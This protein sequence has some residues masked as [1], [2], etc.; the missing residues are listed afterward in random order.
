M[1]GFLGELGILPNNQLCLRRKPF[2]LGGS[3]GELG[4][5][6]PNQLM[7]G[8]QVPMPN[9]NKQQKVPSLIFQYLFLLILDE[10]KSVI[11]CSVFL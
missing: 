3:L 5:L 9:W 4:I 8:S 10:S 2:C 1:G 11:F 6:P 7:P